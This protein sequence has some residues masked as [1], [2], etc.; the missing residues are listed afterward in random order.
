MVS[1]VKPPEQ[2]SP[3]VVGDK[4]Q[5]NKEVKGSDL[6]VLRNPVQPKGRAKVGR[7]QLTPPPEVGTSVK[8]MSCLY[9]GA[10]RI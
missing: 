4:R 2:F 8:Q 3:Y 1:A 9:A 7:P 6:C 5:W 10:A